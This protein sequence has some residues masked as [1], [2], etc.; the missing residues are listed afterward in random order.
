MNAA[1]RMTPYRRLSGN[2]GVLAYRSGAR[3]ISVKFVNG[4]VYT[5]TYASTGAQHIEAMKQL[6]QAGRGLSGYISKHVR[7]NY[8]FVT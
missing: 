3:E 8:A 5:Y 1:K 7:D 2:S 6:A 4:A